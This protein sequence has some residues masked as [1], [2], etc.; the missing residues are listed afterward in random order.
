MEKTSFKSNSIIIISRSRSRSK[1]ACRLFVSHISYS[2]SYINQSER[3]EERKE[4][5][6]RILLS[7]QA[8]TARFVDCFVEQKRTPKRCNFHLFVPADSAEIEKNDRAREGKE[9]FNFR[10]DKSPQ[11]GQPMRQSSRRRNVSVIY[12]LQFNSARR[13][14]RRKQTDHHYGKVQ[15]WGKKIFDLSRMSKEDWPPRRRLACVTQ[16]NLT[17]R[18]ISRE[19]DA[20]RRDRERMLHQIQ[21]ATDVQREKE[22][23]PTVDR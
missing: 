10:H 21:W 18:C 8:E 15:R 19:E 12:P 2:Y 22:R 14:R 3:R 9:K 23:V 1:E 20:R 6:K 7:T 5:R 13:R 4:G 11:L 16:I 17:N